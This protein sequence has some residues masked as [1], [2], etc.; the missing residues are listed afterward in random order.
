MKVNWGLRILLVEGL[1]YTKQQTLD[2]FRFSS[3]SPRP[4][5]P[6]KL[7][8]DPKVTS[9]GAKFE[10]SLESSEH[11]SSVSQLVTALQ[12]AGGFIE[13]A[14]NL[15]NKIVVKVCYSSNCPNLKSYGN[16]DSIIAKS[17]PK[18]KSKFVVARELIIYPYALLNQ[19]GT[20]DN[21]F[22]MTISIQPKDIIGMS[23]DYGGDK[24][25]DKIDVLEVIV[26]ELLHGM[27]MFSY[28]NREFTGYLRYKGP[29]Y[30][31]K[32]ENDIGIINFVEG[33]YDKYLYSGEKSMHDIIQSMSKNVSYMEANAYV[34]DIPKMPELNQIQ[35]FYTGTSPLYFKTK[36][37]K[38]VKIQKS[39]SGNSLGHLS[40]VDYGNSLD[41]LMTHL[42]SRY[43]YF[44]KNETLV[45]GW[46]TAPLGSDTIDILETLGY[47]K[48]SFPQRG[49][50]QLALYEEMRKYN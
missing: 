2:K 29:E 12:I 44:I 35:D 28:V 21:D 50:S 4:E 45:Q 7:G 1:R 39:K 41:Y 48:N 49:K 18:T 46:V 25:D 47:D 19:N 17:L 36:Y 42:A 13:N 33:I 14:L 32:Y 37:N 6:R 26:H 9:P 40:N 24:L 16:D 38:T 3:F 15:A 5:V 22:D 10:F 43:S 31:I 27:G 23:V 11:S 8:I 30:S 20:R 34:H